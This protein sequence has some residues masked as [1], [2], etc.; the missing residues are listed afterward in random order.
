V[1]EVIA[2][3]I[4]GPAEPVRRDCVMD[5]LYRTYMGEKMN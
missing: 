5:K 1:K 4:N 3:P 2:R